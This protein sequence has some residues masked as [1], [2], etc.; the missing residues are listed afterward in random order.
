MSEMNYKNKKFDFYAHASYEC[1]M[2]DFHTSEN[3]LTENQILENKLKYGINN[4]LDNSNDTI[5]YRLRR[6]FINPF[7]IILFVLGI[8]SFVTELVMKTQY[9]HNYTT[10]IIIFCM[11]ALSGIV[12]FTQEMKAKGISDS[13]L[14]M[15]SSVNL[16]RRDGK[17]YELDSEELVAGDVVYLRAGDRVPADMRLFKA[18]DLFI[19]QSILTGESAILKK[20]TDTL[21]ESNIYSYASYKN[22]VFAGSAVIGGV[23]Q[24]VVISVGKD[25]VFGS[26]K[27]KTFNGRNSFDQGA[28][29]IAKVLIRFMC[30]LIPV[31]FIATGITQ[32]DWSTSIL[33]ALSVGVGLTPEMLPMVVNACLA[34]GSSSM[35][36]KQTIVKNI[37]A[38]QG[39]GSM[40]VLC[41]DK[42]GTLTGDQIIL[43]YYMDILGNENQEVL[44]FSYLNSL[45][46]SGVKNHLD[47][48]I[49]K[50][51]E[52]PGREEFFIDLQKRYT[53][54]DEI[55]FDYE[56]KMVSVLVEK[57]KG[58][59]LLSKGNVEKVVS[60]CKYIDYKGKI[61]EMEGDKAESVHAIVDEML[62]D[63][64]K[65]L[66][67]AY[68][69]M[70]KKSISKIDEEDLVLLGYLAFFDA[71]KA[72]AKSAIEKLKKLKV[73]IKV[74]T[75]DEEGVA[76]S[77]CRR[78][79]IPVDN[80]IRG[81]QFEEMSLEEK[82]RSVETVSVFT[83]LSPKQKSTIVKLLQE[84]GHSVGFLGDGMN[85]LPAIVQ[86]DVGI[87]VDQA[88]D[89][90]KE[91]SD[92]ILLK[93]DLNVLEKG[94]LEG[95]KA[96][97]NTRK[98]I[99]ITASS[100]FGN[101]FSIV[102]ASI[103]LPFLPMS[104]LQL[105][106]L[107]L[108]YDILC[109]SLP[110]DYVDEDVYT[111]PQEWSGKNLGRFMRYFGP[112]SSVL[113][114]I[115]FAFLYFILCP[116][117]SANNP[118]LFVALFQTGWFLESMWTQVMILHLLRTKKIPFV[119]S[120][121]SSFALSIT[122]IG[123]VVFTGFAFTPLGALFGLTP[124]PGYYFIFLVCVI[125]SYMVLVSIVKI[126]FVK[127][128]HE[129]T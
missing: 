104:A 36:K 96:F 108:L 83:E 47:E 29:S 75:G 14:N 16:V 98:Y 64:M 89:V 93:K 70:E 15:V 111:R 123:V 13:L 118:V 45:Y 85:D 84:K 129:L 61:L 81:V 6:A 74:L 26:I 62:E 23:G 71:P 43:E 2:Q 1:A 92:V 12:R 41:V 38:M 49:L 87:S 57:E 110:W 102:I 105:L 50:C 114:L 88:S 115:T 72:T 53:K 113:D 78:L 34:K 100:N 35:A 32:G 10:A 107:N 79:K 58:A 80:C 39:F 52:L 99:K 25:T 65:V 31:V 11:L 19:S 119:Q 101:I 5:V 67:V 69:P 20:S 66:A 59:I 125:L 4:K 30:V 91:A 33:F 121:P 3:G 40:D 9:S 56:R 127:K 7:S 95:R 116:R 17:W 48:A 24:G 77:I 60:K 122:L 42:T 44:D 63:G 37:S 90:V 68:K 76:L 8:I 18:E 28:A 55:P 94:I 27:D 22:M 86:S 46:H 109:L 128:Y 106:L 82:Y 126:R 51:R 73:S 103:F 124:L 97:A 21:I 112:I 117:L 120:R 54:L